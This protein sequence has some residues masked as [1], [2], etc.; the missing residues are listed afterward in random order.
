MEKD[1]KRVENG[2]QSEISYGSHT[3]HSKYGSIN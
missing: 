2:N 1:V 3:G